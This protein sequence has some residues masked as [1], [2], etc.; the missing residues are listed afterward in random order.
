VALPQEQQILTTAAS[1]VAVDNLV[2]LGFMGNVLFTLCAMRYLLYG[3]YV[4]YFMGNVEHSW[5]L[6]TLILL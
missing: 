4:T 1:N 6:S 5:F 3:Q 2:C